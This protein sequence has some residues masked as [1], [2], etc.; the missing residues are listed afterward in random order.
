ME[1]VIKWK[2]GVPSEKGVYLVTYRF[3]H[4]LTEHPFQKVYTTSIGTSYWDGF[5]H[6]YE[7]EAS[8]CKI[9]AWCPISEI[10]PYEE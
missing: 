6:S 9:L 8:D 4:Y 10:E 5:W 7:D 2:T 3:G 1:S